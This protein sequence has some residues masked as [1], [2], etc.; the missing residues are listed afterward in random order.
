MKRKLSLRYPLWL[1]LIVYWLLTF[2]LLSAAVVKTHG[3]FGYPLDDTYIHMAMA[4]H[5]VQD[6]FWGTSLTG[7][8]SSSSAPLWT[9]LLA[10]TYRIFGVTDWAPFVLCLLLGTAT[11][12][13]A[14]YLLQ[15]VSSPLRQTA[16]LIFVIAFAPL[17]VLTLVGMEPVLQGLVAL[18]AIYLAANV[19]AS[20]EPRARYMAPL[21]LVAVLVTMTRYEGM[22]LVFAIAVVFFF[23]RRFIAGLAVG[24]AGMLPIVAVGIISVLHGWYFVPA[25]V[26]IKGR[27]ADFALNGLVGFL[28]HLPLNLQLAQQ[29][30]AVLIACLLAYIL[31]ERQGSAGSRERYIVAIFVMM[32]LL[33]LQFAAVGFLSRYEGYI[34]LT[35]TVILADLLDPVVA[36]LS[37][38]RQTGGA[39]YPAATFALLILLASPLV[40]GMGENFLTYPNAVKNIYEQ[41][42]QMGLF[43]KKYYTGKSIVINDIGAIDYLADVKI[44]DMAGIGSM[45][46]ARAIVTNSFNQQSVS[47]LST[48][49]G[50]EIAMV[51]AS[52]YPYEIPSDWIEI[53]QWK[54]NGNVICGD[55]VVNIYAPGARW[56]ETVSAN[57][58][59]FSSSLPATVEQSGSYISR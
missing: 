36:R 58:R 34:V 35:G 11:V 27:N 57:L 56:Q 5:L 41:Q 29:V 19:L 13:Y 49:H 47:T 40:L 8:S 53:G 55:D 1:A 46:V 30:L 10:L 45:D 9:L 24:A 21:L 59:A 32:S 37:D 39:A 26:L 4:R 50:P 33:H 38:R 23:K 25:S 54:I 22:F 14:Y 3:H 42:Y 51:Y 6:G 17:P 44:M 12:V 28:V 18:T 20:G 52:W 16:Y 7:F 48:V 43:I 2:A 31:R 15:K